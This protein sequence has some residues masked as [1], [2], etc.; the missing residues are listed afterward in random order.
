MRAGKRVMRMED[1]RLVD[2]VAFAHR[3]KDM[4]AWLARKAPH[5]RKSP[6]EMI[7]PGHRAH[8]LDIAAIRDDV[9]GYLFP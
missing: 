2:S 6:A 7:R 9:S 5:A 1:D 3:A 4:E 8:M